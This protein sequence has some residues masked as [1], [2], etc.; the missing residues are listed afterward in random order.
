MGTDGHVS[1]QDSSIRPH[2]IWVL[3]TDREHGLWVPT[4]GQREWYVAGWQGSLMQA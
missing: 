4:E 3:G 1:H 2:Q